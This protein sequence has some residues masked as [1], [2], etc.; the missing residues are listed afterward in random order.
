MA[1][2]RQG[3][4]RH[5][6]LWNMSLS[7]YREMCE[8]HAEMLAREVGPETSVLD[9]GCGFGRFLDLAPRWWRGEYLGLD[10]HAEFLAEAQRQ[11]PFRRFL[12]HDLRKSIQTGTTYDLAV[13]IG[14]EGMIKNNAP[15]AWPVIEANVKAA[16]RRQL[17]IGMYR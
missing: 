12:L 1:E 14:I 9:V 6:A 17:W 8:W 4:N 3:R 11:H 16:S 13:G 10:F 15:E 2:A 5:Q 7:W